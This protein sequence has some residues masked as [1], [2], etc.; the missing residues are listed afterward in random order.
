MSARFPSIVLVAFFALMDTNA[1]VYCYCSKCPPHK[2][3]KRRTVLVHLQEDNKRLRNPLLGLSD[4]DEMRL[5]LCIEYTG[6]SLAG[7]P[8]GQGIYTIVI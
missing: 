8:S 5:K 7:I 1:S 2:L 4:L 3:W 6:N